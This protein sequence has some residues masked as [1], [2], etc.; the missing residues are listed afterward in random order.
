MR[1]KQRVLEF[2]IEENNAFATFKYSHRTSPG[3]TSVITV[4]SQTVLRRRT[5]NMVTLMLTEQGSNMDMALNINGMR[6]DQVSVGSSVFQPDTMLTVGSVEKKP[7]YSIKDVVLVTQKIQGVALYRQLHQQFNAQ[8]NETKNK[9][10]VEYYSSSDYLV[11][12]VEKAKL[13]PPHQKQP[14][15]HSRS[16]NK[17][18]P[19]QPYSI[20]KPIQIKGRLIPANLIAS[21]DL[22][23]TE[24]KKPDLKTPP[25]AEEEVEVQEQQEWSRTRAVSNLIDFF[26]DKYQLKSAFRPIIQL[27]SF[28]SSGLQF[29]SPPFHDE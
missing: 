20:H 25:P 24:P 26:K 16:P 14:K 3:K 18:Q 7:S 2:G 8:Y 9:P 23:A 5:Y 15:K 10:A 29:I 11:S 21:C 28:F 22:L 19:K 4:M 27:Y 12:L 17:E 6:D 13:P 1:E